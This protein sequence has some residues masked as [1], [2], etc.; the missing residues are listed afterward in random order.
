MATKNRWM[1]LVGG[2]CPLGKETAK[3][4]VA[5]GASVVSID[6]FPAE[7]EGDHKSGLLEISGDLLDPDVVRAAFASCEDADSISVVYMASGRKELSSISGISEAN[8]VQIEA[9]QT[10]AKEYLN[11]A[12]AKKAS[13]AFILISSV[14]SILQSHS[15]P[16]YGALKA[17]AESLIRAFATFA[18]YRGYGA[19][20]TLRLGYVQYSDA[21]E[22]DERTPSRRAARMLLGARPLVSWDDVS[23]TL[24]ALANL[25][26]P[27]LNGSTFW[28]DG[29]THLLEQTHVVSQSIALGDR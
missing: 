2:S 16:I 12:E 17:A 24:L 20:L 19:F 15:D 22:T 8:R 14:N 7:T 26:N 28:G 29:G 18:N 9:L 10:W 5:S 13:G 4:A 25:N 6:R 1:I 11:A 27:I 23:Q 3:A 21:R